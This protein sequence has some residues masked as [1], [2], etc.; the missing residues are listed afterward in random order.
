MPPPLAGRFTVAVR[1]AAL[2]DAVDAARILAPMRE[3]V[4]ALLAVAG[5]ESGSAQ[6]IVELRLLGGAL[7]RPGRHRSAFGHRDVAYTP[8][9]TTGVQ[10]PPVADLVPAQAAAVLDALAPWST[11]GQLSNF[12]AWA[13]AERLARCYDE[14]TLYRLAALAE[15]YDPA[16]VLGVGQVARYPMQSR[17]GL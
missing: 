6:A 7:A 3:A 9:T 11:G 4:E 8:V 17:K 15:R 13:D 12:G 14:D 2:G 1:Y 5:P 16:A 10:V